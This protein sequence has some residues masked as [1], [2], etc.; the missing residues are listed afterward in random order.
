MSRVVWTRV[1]SLLPGKADYA[2]LRTSWK[3]DVIAGM[4]VGVVALPLAL[5]FGI[6]A[7]LGARAG[8]IIAIVAG[9][10]A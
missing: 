4:T 6:T 3:G 7:G 5:A 10:V 1:A 8:L 9:L 2:G